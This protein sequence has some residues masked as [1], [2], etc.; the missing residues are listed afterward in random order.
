MSDV[1]LAFGR[2]VRSLFRR[3]ILWHLLWPALLASVV[4]M[5]V[6]I[7][8]WGDV[9]QW[10]SGWVSSLGWFDTPDD[11]AIPTLGLLAV[12]VHILIALVLLPLIYFTAIVLV[13]AVAL[14][15][16]L[17]RVSETDYRDLELRRGGSGLGST[18]NALVAA[19]LFL[20]G[21]LLTLPLWLI[22]GAGLVISVIL[23][24]WMNRRAFGYDALMLHADAEE[25][26]R[27]RSEHSGPLF[28]LG[29]ACALLAYV[30]LANLLAPAVCGLAYVHYLLEALR[31][32]RAARG[33]HIVED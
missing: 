10:V 26:R 13:A 9:V 3:D 2:A 7:A 22:P 21:M 20:L 17:A 25:M 4:W 29:V 1:F 24:A 5:A 8:T 27:L 11:A 28:Q 33:W 31:R 16:M 15:M 12:M 30:P 19:G 23:T 32:D 14:P 18:W 6:A